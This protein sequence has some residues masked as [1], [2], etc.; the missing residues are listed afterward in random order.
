MV[1]CGPYHVK[2]QQHEEEHNDGE[3]NEELD[4]DSECPE[5]EQEGIEL[6]EIPEDT[7][8][9]DVQGPTTTTKNDKACDME[10]EP[11]IDLGEASKE[12]STE[13]IHQRKVGWLLIN[14]WGLMGFWVAAP[15]DLNHF[16]FDQNMKY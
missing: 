12:E 14:I 10:I 3:A 7:T 2:D 6:L 1:L 11:E 16:C 8:N 13:E 5:D 9:M 4:G 15:T